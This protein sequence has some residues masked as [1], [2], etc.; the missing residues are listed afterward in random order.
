MTVYGQENSHDLMGVLSAFV[1]ESRSRA[2]TERWAGRWYKIRLAIGLR[3][4]F[5][6]DEEEGVDVIWP[7]KKG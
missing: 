3:F 7:R 2:A 1:R 6:V 5:L 4:F